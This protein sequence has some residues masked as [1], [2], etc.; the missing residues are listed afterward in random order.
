[1]NVAAAWNRFWFSPSSLFD[2]AVIRLLCVSVQIFML[3]SASFSDL[4]YVLSLPASMYS[5]LPILKLLLLPLGWGALPTADLIIGIFWLTL[6]MGFLALA[7]LL[8]NLTLLLFCLGNVLLQAFTYSFG[9][10]HH[11]EAI[12][13]IALLALAMAP[14]GRVL[15]IDALIRRRHTQAQPNEVPLLD[16]R[17][18]FAG[19]PLKLLQCFFP[20][21]YLSAVSSKL[22]TSG[23]GWA[24]GY[25][26]QY[27]M[28][29]DSMRW[30]SQLG[31]YVAQFHYPILVLQW[32]ILLFQ[33]TFFLVIFF[34]KLRWIYLPIGLCFHIGIYLTL[35]A[36]FIQWIVLYAVFIPWSELLRWLATQ[37]V[38]IPARAQQTAGR[39]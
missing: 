10:S 22:A 31:L 7:G 3:L 13:M 26:L 1:M 36:P 5:P 2:L 25:T 15:S 37:R 4:Q 14:S 21:M 24:N 34:P 19:W 17:S 39:S 28:I 38:Q 8:T 18:P 23:L 33:T 20:L 12:M 9:D 29:Q 35:R 27:Y 30:G 11:R 32:I 16:A 6:L